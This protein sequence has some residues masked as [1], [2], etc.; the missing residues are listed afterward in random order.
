SGGTKFNRGSFV[1]KGVSQGDLDKAAGGFGLRAYGLA[2]APSVKTHPARAAR[3]A[4]LHQWTN[5]QTEGWWRQAF[6]V[7][8]IPYDY[9]DPR[10]PHHPAT[11]RPTYEV[12]FFG[13]GG[14]RGAAE[15]A[16]LG[17]NPTPYQTTADTPN[18]GTWA[19]TE[20]TRIGMGLEGLLHLRQFI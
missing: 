17:P 10:A 2:S 1:I 5:T 4:V 13:P 16:P 18:V 15:G 12:S 11:R 6:D 14:G 7:Y 9:I 3:I 8:G 19:Q 20:D